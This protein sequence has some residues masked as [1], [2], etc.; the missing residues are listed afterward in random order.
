MIAGC[1]ALSAFAVG[2]LAGLASDNPAPQV[3]GR[4][5]ICMLVCYPVGLVIGM[6]CVRVIAAHVEAHR[7][8]NPIPDEAKLAPA[9]D[10]PSTGEEVIVV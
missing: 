1:F 8:A 7:K 3:L 6:V 9:S 5:I 2:V 4:A 10:Q